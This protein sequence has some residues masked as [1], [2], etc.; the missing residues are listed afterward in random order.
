MPCSSLVTRSS[1]LVVRW[2]RDSTTAPSIVAISRVAIERAPRG[3]NPPFAQRVGQRVER[4]GRALLIGL[5]RPHKRSA[6]TLQILAELSLAYAH[7]ET[8][9]ELRAGVLFA[10]GEHFT[11]GL[12]LVDVGPALAAGESPRSPDGR[13]PWRPDGPWSKPVVAAVQGWLVTLGIALL[14]AADIRVAAA[15]SRFAQIEIRRGI[16]PFGGATVRLPHRARIEGGQAAFDRLTPDVVELFNSADGAEGTRSFIERRGDQRP[17]GDHGRRYPSSGV[18]AEVAGDGHQRAER[19]G[20]QQLAQAAQRA[21]VE[22]QRGG[23]HLPADHGRERQRPRARSRADAGR[24]RGQS[25]AARARAPPPRT[26][27]PAR[28]QPARAPQTAQAVSAPWR[29]GRGRRRLPGRRSRP[30]YRSGSPPGRRSTGP[31]A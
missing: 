10:H 23:E 17:T 5:N 16:Y 20:Q 7:L 15:D 11:G 2:A 22:Q 12:D 31:A 28:P 19:G 4:D 13:D 6:F 24:E 25:R 8:D 29:R 14:L 9:E 26:R 3:G 18:H 30:P 1:G 27:A 21:E